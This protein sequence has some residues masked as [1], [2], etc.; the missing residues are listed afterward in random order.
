[1]GRCRWAG[2]RAVC[3]NENGGRGEMR[4]MGRAHL[5]AA[6]ANNPTVGSDAVAR[7]AKPDQ[8]LTV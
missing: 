3:K 5:P 8:Q 6:D 1:M 4:A 2:G 7:T